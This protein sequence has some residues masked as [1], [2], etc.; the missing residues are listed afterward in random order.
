L[1][2]ARNTDVLVAA[3]R[4]REVQSDP[5]KTTDA[6]DMVTAE[7]GRKSLG[8][9]TPLIPVRSPIEQLFLSWFFVLFAAA[10]ALRLAVQYV[11]SSEL[12]GALLDT[13]K[14][15]SELAILIFFTLANQFLASIGSTIASLFTNGVV[16][17]QTE[18]SSQ[19]ARIQVQSE[20]ALDRL[21]NHPARRLP[22]AIM[23]MGSLYYYVQRMDELN[24]L[25]WV[26]SV[27]RLFDIILYFVPTV[28]YAY[29]IGTVLWKLF[30]TSWFFQRFPWQYGLT[31]RFLH[32]DG[33]G[34]LLPLGDLCLRMMYVAVIPTV[35]SA[36]FLLAYFVP[37][38]ALGYLLA[39]KMLLFGFTPLILGV[40]VIGLVIGF[41]P[42]FKFHLTI[43]TFRKEW[44]NQLKGLADRIVVEKA[45]I[46]RS[47]DDLDPKRLG[48]RL[49]LVGELQSLYDASRKV[50]MWPVDGAQ[51]IRIWGSVALVGGQLLGF[52]ETVRQA[53]N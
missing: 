51:V 17:A 5:P 13:V 3:P 6:S 16:S 37:S 34:G 32:P 53:L 38:G 22:A 28:C 10:Y 47:S 35:L 11:D 39:N 18:D 14:I 50:R 1:W 9:A 52:M 49:H 4:G 2:S 40:G 42:L 33:A 25:D 48:E 30:A 21:L 15:A 19:L 8:L 41:L 46:L 45:R 36:V 20:R 26:R 31:P 43:L 23:A 27:L 29:F 12:P 7:Q 24:V 44:T